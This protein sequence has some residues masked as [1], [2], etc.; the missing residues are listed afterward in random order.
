[1]YQHKYVASFKTEAAHLQ[2]LLSSIDLCEK[3]YNGIFT[4]KN[5]VFVVC[6]EF[7]EFNIYIGIILIIL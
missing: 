7:Y 3:L 6:S 1:M 5:N 2:T 4:Q